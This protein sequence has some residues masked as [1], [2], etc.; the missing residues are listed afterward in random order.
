MVSYTEDDG[1]DGVCFMKKAMKMRGIA[2]AIC[3]LT[4]TPLTAGAFC[5]EP[6]P[7]MSKPVKPT[8][9]PC[10]DTYSNTHDCDD[11]TFNS[12][13]SA[14]ENYE[15]EV[16][17]YIRDLQTYVDDAVEYAECEIADLQ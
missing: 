4:L 11:F 5:S 7:P 15:R 14:M 8:A 9:P 17:S 2:A 13:L 12:Y 16:D 6:S 3:I 10:V 1:R